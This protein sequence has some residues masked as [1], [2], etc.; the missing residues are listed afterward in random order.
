MLLPGGGDVLQ[1]DLAEALA[2]GLHARVVQA[3]E[4][5]DGVVAPVPL[6]DVALKVSEHL[7]VLPLVRVNRRLL[8]LKVDSGHLAFSFGGRGKRFRRSAFGKGVGG[9]AR[10]GREAGGA[11]H[12]ST[13]RTCA[14]TFMRA[15]FF[16]EAYLSAAVKLSARIRC[17]CS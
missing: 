14:R 2:L 7:R 5:V 13:H 10:E 8:F 4:D 9:L 1:G 11:L 16:P 17:V 12:T 15:S 3:D 6:Q